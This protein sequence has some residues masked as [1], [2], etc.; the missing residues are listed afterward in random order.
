LNSLQ[1]EPVD[2][3]VLDARLTVKSCSLKRIPSKLIR[4]RAQGDYQNSD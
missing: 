3:A 1:E 4:N 2:A